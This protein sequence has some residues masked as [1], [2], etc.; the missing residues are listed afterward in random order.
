MP[1]WVRRHVEEQGRAM[2]T[3]TQIL[4]NQDEARNRSNVNNTRQREFEKHLERMR[5]EHDLKIDIR[6]KLGE[7]NKDRIWKQIKQ[8]HW[9]EEVERFATKSQLRNHDQ[10]LLVKIVAENSL[11]NRPLQD[12][13]DSVREN[14]QFETCDYFIEF[15]FN[16]LPIKPEAVKKVYQ[17]FMGIKINDTDTAATILNTYIR[18]YRRVFLALEMITFETFGIY[19]ITEELAVGRAYLGL[20][21]KWKSLVRT[22]VTINGKERIPKTFKLLASVLRD[23]EATKT[24]K[25]GLSM[26]P[27]TRTTP[28]FDQGRRINAIRRDRRNDRY[29]R[30]NRKGFG[31]QGKPARK[32]NDYKRDNKGMRGQRRRYYDKYRDGNRGKRTRRPFNNERKSGYFRD[33]RRRFRGYSRKAI[34]FRNNKRKQG[35]LNNRKGKYANN[36]DKSN[37]RNDKRG[38]RFGKQYDKQYDRKNDRSKDKFRNDRKGKETIE[39]KFGRYNK[40]KCYK[41]NRK[42]HYKMIVIRYMKI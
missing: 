3:M 20:P 37:G 36:I 25:I 11:V 4:A 27:I 19:D 32:R 9:Y 34:R 35:W 30:M 18:S 33:Q 42:G 10:A 40:Y 5:I 41:C 39:N 15:I 26:D 38:K 22:R 24:K 6:N 21:P 1:A 29:S 23:V 7:P 12:Y 2:T 16:I 14:G 13:H 8:L 28:K 31:Y 17:E